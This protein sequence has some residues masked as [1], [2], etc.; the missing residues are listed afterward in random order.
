MKTIKEVRAA[1]I[2]AKKAAEAAAQRK[3]E[4]D[5]IE[6]RDIVATMDEV[7]NH[8]A[9]SYRNENG[10]AVGTNGGQYVQ[11]PDGK[12]GTIAASSQEE[13]D[14]IKE[15]MSRGIEGDGMLHQLLVIGGMPCDCCGRTEEELQADIRAAEEYAKA[16]GYHIIRDIDV[17]EQLVDA[18]YVKE[19]LEQVEVN[20]ITYIISYGEK[21]AMDLAG[22]TVETLDNL[23]SDISREDVKALLLRLLATHVVEVDDDYDDDEDCEDDDEYYEDEEYY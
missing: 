20:G 7:V 16:H 21:R 12:G 9:H 10:N 18:E 23:N 6:P 5:A 8:V 4:L 1:E 2:A 19:D 11:I 14:A 13:L 22:N 17:A 3:A 15:R